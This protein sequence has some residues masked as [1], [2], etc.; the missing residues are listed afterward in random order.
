MMV[1]IRRDSQMPYR[2]STF[3]TSLE[4]VARTERLLPSEWINEAANDVSAAFIEYA[5]PLIPQVKSYAR[6]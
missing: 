1:A 2:S 6:L 3:L 5:S 4:T